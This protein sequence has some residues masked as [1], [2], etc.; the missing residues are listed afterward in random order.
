MGASIRGF[1]FKFFMFLVFAGWILVWIMSPTSA[2]FTHFSGPIAE[3]VSLKSYGQTGVYTLIYTA[4][5]LFMA[6]I[7]A[8]YLSHTKKH[9]NTNEGLRKFLKVNPWTY[10]VFLRGPL[11]LISLAELALLTASIALYTWTLAKEEKILSLFLLASRWERKFNIVGKVFGMTGAVPFAFLFFPVARL[12]SL[13]RLINIPFEHAVRYHIWTG[14]ITMFLW[15]VH[16]LVYILYWTMAN[17]SQELV[18]WHKIDISGLTGLFTWIVGL[19]MW[20]TSLAPV[21]KHR[22]E[23]FYHTH[24]LYFV[25]IVGFA[26]HLGEGWLAIVIAGVFLFF[27]DRL[28]RFLQ[29]M[30]HVEVVSA[31]VISPETL[32]LTL[33][34]VP[35]L[36]YPAASVIFLN[37]PAIS[38]LQWHPFTVTSCST[39]DVDRITIFVKCSGSWTCKLKSLLDQER[40]NENS[41]NYPV[42]F[43]AAVEGPHG[44]EL[45]HLHAYPTLI[46]VAGGSGVGPF[47]SILKDLLYKVHNKLRLAPKKIVFILAVKFSEELQILHSISPSSIAPDFSAADFLELHAY[48]TRESESDLESPVK[49]NELDHKSVIHFAGRAASSGNPNAKKVRAV[50]K[51]FGYKL[52]AATILASFAGYMLIAGLVHRFYIYPMD[53]NT[54]QVCS[55]SGRGF[56]SLLEYVVAICAFGGGTILLWNWSKSRRD[57]NLVDAPVIDPSST[58]MRPSKVVY[59]RRPD[60]QGKQLLK[61]GEIRFVI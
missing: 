41:H 57:S 11:A 53:H 40:L 24:Q 48:V 59:G 38:R 49:L 58:K 9:T 13:F 52:Y 5:V 28:F 31:K 21:R 2:F 23:L 50:A 29:S 55:I 33:A 56:A 19:L 42:H 43:E 16:G 12:S 51:T 20:G 6:F 36:K 37:L 1:V 44:H 47:I 61:Q 15:T 4:P 14:H 39:V 60:F 25:F 3:R 35:D 26:L 7:A 17:K 54:Y 18:R 46:F 32:E 10:P 22:F 45:D 34:K 30:R 8:L 27:I